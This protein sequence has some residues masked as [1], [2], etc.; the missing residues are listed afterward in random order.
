MTVAQRNHDL[1]SQVRHRARPDL[2]AGGRLPGATR[3]TPRD[4]SL[5]RATDPGRNASTG[6]RLLSARD[7]VLDTLV[8]GRRRRPRAT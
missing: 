3:L 2:G 8:A 7:R 4:V 5:D 6:R 1:R